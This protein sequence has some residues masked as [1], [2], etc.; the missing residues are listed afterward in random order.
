MRM[1]SAA[2]RMRMVNGTT[3]RYCPLGRR[4]SVFFRLPQ[5][6]YLLRRGRR[7]APCAAPK[8]CCSTAAFTD[9][10]RWFPQLQLTL[11]SPHT[12]C[13]K[14]GTDNRNACIFK[15]KM[16]HPWRNFRKAVVILAMRKPMPVHSVGFL[17]MRSI[18]WESSEEYSIARQRDG[19][20]IFNHDR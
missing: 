17:Y 16:R 8:K 7:F 20:F 18:L 15:W 11:R 12:V 3:I 5:L 13:A 1:E 6:W 9:T 19:V 2:Q 10:M 14:Q 4:Q